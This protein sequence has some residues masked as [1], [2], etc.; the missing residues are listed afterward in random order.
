ME[1]SKLLCIFV[2]LLCTVSRHNIFI[3]H[4]TQYNG[5][6][7]WRHLVCYVCPLKKNQSPKPT[8]TS[9]LGSNCNDPVSAKSNLTCGSNTLCNYRS[10]KKRMGKD[11]CIM[12]VCNYHMQINNNRVIIVIHCGSAPL[13]E[14]NVMNAKEIH[15]GDKNN[16]PL[17]GIWLVIFFALEWNFRRIYASLVCPSDHIL[18]L[19]L[20][21]GTNYST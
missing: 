2:S 5:P 3:L 7:I 20:C 6:G 4:R 16:T 11:I 14:L 15:R 13:I 1:T 21:L 12:Y 19:F 9:H 18:S 17:S 8:L 10:Y